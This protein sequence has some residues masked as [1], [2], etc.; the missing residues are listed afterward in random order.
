MYIIQVNLSL[1]SRHPK[2]LQAIN[3]ISQSVLAILLVYRLQVLS[4]LNSGQTSNI[5]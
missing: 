4:A 5:F 2:S 1:P 3:N